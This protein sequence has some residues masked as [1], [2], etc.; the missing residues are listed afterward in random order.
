[1]P[2]IETAAIRH[3]HVKTP[4]FRIF[5]Y[6]IVGTCTCCNCGMRV[7]QHEAFNEIMM[8]FEELLKGQHIEPYEEEED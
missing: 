1:M 2:G 3:T 8:H 6:E 4:C 7:P 5:G